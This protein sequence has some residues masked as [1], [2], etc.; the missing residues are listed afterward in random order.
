MRS[1]GRSTHGH[2]CGQASVQFKHLSWPGGGLYERSRKSLEKPDIRPR[3][4]KTREPMVTKISWVAGTSRI[5]TAMQNFTTMRWGNFVPTYAKFPIKCLLG[6]FWGFSQHATHRPSHRFWRS[7]R[8]TTSFRAR[9]CLLGVTKTKAVPIFYQ[10]IPTFATHIYSR[11]SFPHKYI[12]CA[13]YIGQKSH[14]SVC[15]KCSLTQNMPKNAFSAGVG[16][17]TTFS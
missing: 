10:A 8:Q 12:N 16:K 17:L 13:H 15:Q 5:S 14:F 4:R 9:M 6:L 7:I 11:R 3:H 2:D 1:P